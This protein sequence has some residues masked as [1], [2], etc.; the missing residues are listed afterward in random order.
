MRESQKYSRSN[1]GLL[2]RFQLAVW[3]DLSGK[4]ELIDS[5]PNEENRREVIEMFERLSALNP[6]DVG[7]TCGHG[8]PYLRFAADAQEIFSAWLFGHENRLRDKDNELPEC[9]ESH[10]GKYASLVP[11]I[12]LVLHLAEGYTGPV[13]TKSLAKAISWA[14][15]LESHAKRLYAPIIGADFVSARALAR[16]LIDKKMTKLL[17]REIYRKGWANLSTP[18][19]ARNAVEILVDHDWLYS[20]DQIPGGRGGRPTTV[21]FVNPRI[22][23]GVG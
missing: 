10:F 6:A 19:E 14:I 9:L 2:Q 18:D 23:E 8:V 5:A 1:D 16:R 13:G 17:V 7:A 20:S 22:Y 15:Y 11:S 4:F 12:A 21:Y 3:P